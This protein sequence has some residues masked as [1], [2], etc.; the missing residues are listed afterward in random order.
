MERVEEQILRYLLKGCATLWEVINH[1]DVDIKSAVEALNRFK[2]EGYI[3]AKDD[4][5]CLS[6]A[7]KDFAMKN[8]IRKEENF[9]CKNCE[10]TGIELSNVFDEA[11]KKFKK[12]FKGRPSE[13]AEFDQGVV[14]PEVS[15]RRAAFVYMRGDLENKKLLFLGD[16]DLTSIAMMLTGLPKEI[17]VIEV[18]E[19]IVNY[20]NKVA[21]EYNLNV[22]AELY[23][24][25][26]P[27]PEKLKGKFDVFLTDP[28]ETVA[29][30]R[31]FFSRCIEGLKGEG[32]SGYFGVSHYESSLK[33]W[34]GI[35]KDLLAMNLVITD[36]LRDFNKYLLTGERI[37]T[38][39]FRVVKEAPFPPKAPDYPW[40]RSTFF[41][42][43]LI[44]EPNPLITEKVN[45]KRELYYDED[46]YV[47]LP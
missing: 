17:R 7:G 45:W 29:G 4:K 34:F 40:Y 16:D 47:A 24:A 8:N 3:E 43:E 5:I 2:S 22:E 35:E 20:I 27:L 10:G 39:G 1:Q 23:N 13:T 33:K 31:L 41:R 37:L 6:D 30:M 11:I 28:V 38:E 44:G 14:P 15:F 12:I 21:K 18:D 46:T 36:V 26:D 25:V 9:I 42:V 19:R 32:G